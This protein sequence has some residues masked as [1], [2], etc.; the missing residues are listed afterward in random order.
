MGAVRGRA[1]VRDAPVVHHPCMVNR[2]RLATPLCRCFYRE[3]GVAIRY[4]KRR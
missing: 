3:A 1:I 2:P 4:D